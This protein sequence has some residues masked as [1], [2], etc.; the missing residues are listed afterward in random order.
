MSVIVAVLAVIAALVVGYWL[1][2]TRPLWRLDDWVWGWDTE[3][4]R[5]GPAWLFREAYAAVVLACHPR[6]TWRAVR[7]R[8]ATP[9][10]PMEF[11]GAMKPKAPELDPNWAKAKEKSE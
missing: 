7:G 8:H 9:T 5:N 6:A 1:G 4:R 2:R 11:T 10:A 3:P